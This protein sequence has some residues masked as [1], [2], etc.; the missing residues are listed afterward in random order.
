[1]R[2]AHGEADF[3]GNARRL[4]R[5]VTSRVAA[6]DH[7]H[8]LAAPTVVN[9]LEVV[10][11][12][13]F[14]V[15]RARIIRIF[16]IPMVTVSDHKHIKLLDMIGTLGVSVFDRPF[17]GRQAHD[18]LHDMIEANALIDPKNSA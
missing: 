9:F 12:N 4:N 15:E 11:V 18:L 14:A 16:R 13:E 17:A 8:V 10:R 7:Q 3:L 5:H 1:M 2:I 6:P